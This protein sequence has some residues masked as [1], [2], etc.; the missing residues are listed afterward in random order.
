[1]TGGTQAPLLGRWGEDLVAADLRKKGWKIRNMN[2]RCRFGEIDI[3]AEKGGILALVEV[4][5]RKNARFAPAR[6]FV[7]AGKQRKL[8]IAAEFYLMEQPTDLQ[9]RFDVV[10]VYAPEGASTREPVIIYIENA[11]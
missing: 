4:K 11:F 1:M 3:I 10:E 5:L 2:Y 8:R 7:T 6:A 9:P